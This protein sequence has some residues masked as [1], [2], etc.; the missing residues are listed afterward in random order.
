MRGEPPHIS[1]FSP[2]NLP[3][4]W[5]K[6]GKNHHTLSSSFRCVALNYHKALLCT[7]CN[8]I[9]LTKNV[10]FN[11]TWKTTKC[12]KCTNQK[13]AKWWKRDYDL[14]LRSEGVDF[15]LKNGSRGTPWNWKTPG[16]GGSENTKC[17]FWPFIWHFDHFGGTSIFDTFFVMI[18]DFVFFHFLMIFI[19]CVLLIFVFLWFSRFCHFF[20]FWW[21]WRKHVFLLILLIFQV[22]EFQGKD[23]ALFWPLL[24]TIVHSHGKHLV[25]VNS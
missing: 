20:W 2:V 7:T 23:K 25:M 21:F 22:S 3:D 11:K 24:P 5:T 13:T 4:I 17:Q 16:P 10:S 14:P 19:F 1:S 8:L 6:E 12:W 15:G 9:N 18:Y